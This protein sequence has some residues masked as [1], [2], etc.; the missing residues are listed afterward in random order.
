MATQAVRNAMLDA[1]IENTG[2]DAMLSYQVNDSTPSPTVAGDLG[3]RL[4]FFM[5]VMG[6]GSS[7]EALVG[8]APVDPTASH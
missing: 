2:I 3:I 6:G 4:N 1:G 7:T 8:I 5:D